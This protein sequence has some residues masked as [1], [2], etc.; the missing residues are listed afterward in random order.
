MLYLIALHIIFVVTWFAGL[1]YIVRLF[2]YH[3][4]AQQKAEPERTIL[5]NQFKIMQKRLWYGITWPSA[6]ITFIVG[7]YMVWM[8]PSYLSQAYFLLKLCFV[9]ALA[10]YQIQCHYIFKEL[11][12]DIFKHSSLWLR[13][14]NE[15]ASV[16]L[17]AIVFLIVLKQNNNAVWFTLGL[18]IFMTALYIGIQ[19]Y[20]KNREKNGA[21]NE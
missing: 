17:V 13:A 11:Q 4:E 12:K 15:V 19:L 3:I 5:S 18:V 16:L 2:V 9:F 10:L 14:F 20:K 6:I 21:D 8:N 7:P 1:F